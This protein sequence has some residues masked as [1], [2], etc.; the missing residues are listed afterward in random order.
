MAPRKSYPAAGKA[1]VVL[2]A[3]REDQPLAQVA[4]EPGVPPQQLRRLRRLQP[5]RWQL[6]ALEDLPRLLAG[7][8]PQERSQPV[9]PAR[10]L[11]QRYAEIGRLSPQLA[12]LK[13]CT[14]LGP[15]TVRG[16]SA[17]CCSAVR[18]NSRR[19]PREA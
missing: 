16:G 14:P 15:A 6:T 1:Q 19:S 17:R 13:S 8:R 5:S 12:W 3:L 9:E 7:D 18:R 11:E 4:A 10:R 2:A